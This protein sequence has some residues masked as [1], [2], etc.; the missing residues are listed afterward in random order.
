MADNNEKLGIELVVVTDKAVRETKNLSGAIL[1]STT[2][3]KGAGAEQKKLGA[4][5]AETKAKQAEYT[6]ALRRAKEAQVE[7]NFTVQAFGPK[8]RDAAE[9]AKK[10]AAAQ[11]EAKRAAIGA[12]NALGD[13][14]REAQEAAKAEGDKLAPATKRAA[15]QIESMGRDASRAE[16]ELRRLDL[17]ILAASKAAD[18]GG[19]SFGAMFA[20]FGG[21][22]GAAAVGLATEKLKEGAA[23]VLET[24]ASYETLRVA[25]ETTTGSSA[26]AASVFERL[27]KFAEKT[28][29]GVAELTESFIKL[30]ARGIEPTDRLL[31][32]M[33]N[34]AS[35][36]GKTLDDFTEAIADAVTGEN[37]R[38]KEFGIVGKKNG[39]MI[40]YTFRGVTEEVRFSADA[41][42]EYLTRIGESNFAGGMER[43]SQ[44]LSGMWSTMQDQAGSLA[45]EFTKGLAPALKEIMTG[46][47][48]VDE[49][50]K[51]WIRELGG[52]LGVILKGF[53]SVMR[54]IV[55][56]LSGENG[57][58]AKFGL[59][60]VATGG[61][62][63]PFKAASEAAGWLSSAIYGE[64]EAIATVLPEAQELGGV[65]L[66]I[67]DAMGSA[68]KQ[69]DL[70]RGA[71]AL[72]TEALRLQA[73]EQAYVAEQAK[74]AAT[75]I[76]P[77]VPTKGFS[78][79]SKGNHNPDKVKKGKKT[80]EAARIFSD[81]ESGGRSAMLSGIEAT[82]S[83]AADSAEQ[84]SAAAEEFASREAERT[85]ARLADIDR[86]M[87]AL[88]AKGVAE[89]MQIDLLFWSIDQESEGE[90]RRAELQDQRI[91][92]EQELAR[93]QYRTAK[94]DEQREK[95]QTKIEEGEHK[96]RLLQI[97]RAQAQEEKEQAKK[98]KLFGVLNS[99]IQS[100]GAS[101]IDALE[102][103]AEGE[104][105]AVAKG[106]SEFAKGV[107]NKMILKSLEEFALAAAS[108]AGIVTA[109]L[110][111]GHLIAGGLA[112]AAAAAA[113]GISAGF[114][115]VASSAGSGSASVPKT[116]GGGGGGGYSG[117]SSS[118][119]SSGS[120]SSS[121]GVP[122]SYDDGS[123]YAGKMAAIKSA[124]DSGS[125][126]RGPIYVLGATSDQVA[127]AF[128][129]IDRDGSRSLGSAAGKRGR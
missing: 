120:S 73:E 92:R 7:H 10:L 124:N 113:G 114:G 80:K 47:G 44:T 32:S 111:P 48:S 122:I 102:Q 121:N 93:F 70:W 55:D 75:L 78:L 79:D 116:P 118:S 128:R 11:E 106:V 126:S 84:S 9:S 15:A 17:S 18:K 60:S 30:G 2:A 16:G 58:I 66:E 63:L 115:A 26:K 19:K 72:L 99:G 13:V 25:L 54:E 112:A 1:E 23:W 71:S 64:E 41:I 4:Q 104:K 27:Q 89:S 95:A 101:L 33:G 56:T 97:S 94:T 68:I 103:Q 81:S 34:T 42:T 36:M 53:V 3:A 61:L 67:A 107:R 57:A 110:A 31:T 100:L 62:Y 83:I 96:K 52:D 50:T 24:G 91:A 45:D 5:V 85:E 87:E 6:E 46:I 12:A 76:G 109:G 74:L 69:T 22:L 125:N 59:L 8:S 82:N 14:A 117:G 40:A 49:S 65:T 108:A 21:N 51:Q 38:L 90:K 127:T 119:S 37:E 28:P 43:Q 20:S 98:L 88:E 129:K 77:A 105:G 39:D 123:M 86:E 35:S 29:Y